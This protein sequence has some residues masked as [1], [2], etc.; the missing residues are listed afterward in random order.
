VLTYTID[1]S[2]GNTIKE[3]LMLRH[4]DALT[5]HPTTM[6]NYD[7]TLSFEDVD[8]TEDTIKAVAK[9]VSGDVYMGDIDSLA[10]SY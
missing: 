5:P 6:Y 9:R 10:A 7:A 2:S 8:I 1:N 3:V 4:P